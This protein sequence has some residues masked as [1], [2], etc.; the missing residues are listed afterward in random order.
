MKID[1]DAPIPM[2]EH[3]RCDES[4]MFPSIWTWRDAL[5][6]RDWDLYVFPSEEQKANIMHMAHKL[7]LVKQHYP[8]NNFKIQSWLRTTL[9]NVAIGGSK[10]SYHCKGMAVD[11]FVEGKNQQTVRDDLEPWLER[12]GL[13][14][15]RLKPNQHWVHLD[16]GEPK[17]NLRYFLP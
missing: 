4:M 3:F 9:Y 17:F 2:L 7:S 1:L 5:Y 15:E 6:Q 13:R 11:I 16:F 8:F 10:N 14:M 12:L